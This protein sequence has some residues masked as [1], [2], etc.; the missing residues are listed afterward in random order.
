[1]GPIVG[2]EAGKIQIKK[3]KETEGNT[4]AISHSRLAS[5][6]AEESGRI[7]RRLLEAAEFVRPPTLQLRRAL[8]FMSVHNESGNVNGVV[9]GSKTMN[10]IEP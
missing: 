10:L 5:D 6:T 4:V 9:L 3:E 7:Y 8:M 2:G 1:M